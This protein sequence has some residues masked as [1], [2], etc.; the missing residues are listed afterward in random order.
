MKT[1]YFYFL[2][3]RNAV[4]K[5]ANY[6]LFICCIL[7][8]IFLSCS[9][10]RSSQP[11]QKYEDLDAKQNLQG[12]W[13]N[14][15]QGNC[16]FRIKGDTICY[17]DSLVESVK[18]SVYA[19]TLY[20]ENSTQTKYHILQLT[21]HTFKFINS[22]GDE[23]ALSKDDSD[24][25]LNLFEK[26]R[27]K[28]FGI[29]QGVL[30]K[31]DSVLVYGDTRYHAYSQVNPTTF[32]V[33]RQTMNEEGV[34]VDQAYYDNIVHIAVYIGSKA[35]LSR[36]YRKTDFSSIVPDEYI[37]RCILSDII[38]EKATEKGVHFTAI[39]TEPDSFTSY[40]VNMIVDCNG[41]TSMS[42]R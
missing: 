12:I 7:L 35:L 2:Y 39:L 19:D 21:D 1:T 3:M 42:V 33:L 9:N 4:M 31:R 29:N 30:L 34:S 20:L 36:D 23:I 8:P 41:K 25:F 10:N 14:E 37:S 6:T 40:Q 27:Q 17:P 32:K 24:T 5:S 22:E 38:I 26:K 11:Q 28:A 13:I 16:A 15:A 18:F